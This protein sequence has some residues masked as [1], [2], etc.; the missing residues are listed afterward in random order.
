MNELMTQERW[1]SLTPTERGILRDNS[2]LNPQ[3]SGW[4]GW[5]VEVVTDYDETRRFIIDRSTG[6]KPCHIEISRRGS[7][8]GPAAENHYKSVKRLYNA[9]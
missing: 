3:L 6:W 7:F 8:G 4:E 2:G 9:R 5:R 1:D